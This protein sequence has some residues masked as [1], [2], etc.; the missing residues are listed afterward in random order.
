MFIVDKYKFF[1]DQSHKQANTKC[2]LV[3]LIMERFILS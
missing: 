1:L 3:Q 2:F